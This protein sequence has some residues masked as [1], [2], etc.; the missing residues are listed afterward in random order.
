MATSTRSN[1]R[2]SHRQHTL[3]ERMTAQ[4]QPLA[5]GPLETLAQRAVDAAKSAGATY[6]DARLTRVVQ[7]LY[8]VNQHPDGDFAGESEILGI[9]VRALV[10]GYWGFAASPV[11]ESDEAVRL[12]REAVAQAQINAKGSKRVVEMG[13]AA[14][15]TGTWSTPVAIDPFAV[16]I[17]EKQNFI[18]YWVTCARRLGLHFDEV[19]SYVHFARQERVVATTDG[20]YFTQTQFESGGRLVTREAGTNDVSVDIE[21]IDVCGKG[22]ELF[23]DAHIPEQLAAMRATIHDIRALPKKPITVGRYT[24]VCDGATMARVTEQTIGLA[25]QLDRALGYEANSTGTSYLDDPLGMVGQFQAAAAPV[26][27]TANRSVPTQLATVKWDDEG[28]EPTQCTLVKDG[29]LTDF[30]TTREQ[31]S[32]LAPYYTKHGRP[33]RSHGYAAGE[34]ALLITMQHMPNLAFEPNPSKVELD[35][36]IAGVANG[37]LVTKGTVNT[38]Q[39]A[40]NGILVGEM[41][42]ITNGRLG[43]SAQG[44]AIQFNTLDFWRRVNAVGGASTRMTVSTTQYDLFHLNILLYGGGKGAPPQLT[45][46]SVSGAAAVIP[47]QPIIDLGRKA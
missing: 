7:H 44:G 24:I 9:G 47:N 30:Q 40:R 28:V 46:H 27:I 37:V 29:V 36:L 8:Y 43:P 34:D 1:R 6:A 17:E 15:I 25:T 31:A 18:E 13:S 42:K 12:A 3:A 35:D 21:G 33:I 38:D 32:W 41:R 11:W 45:S 4:S 2:G 19:P 26:T 39:Q 20:S 10:N 23:L 5:R 22:W 16:T 14:P